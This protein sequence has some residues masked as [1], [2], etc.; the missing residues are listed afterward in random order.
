MKRQYRAV[1]FDLDTKA[2]LE[3]LGSRTKG[4]ALI[5]KSMKEF[6]FVHRQ[7]SGYRSI[8]PLN[9][10]EIVAFV[11]KIG[12]SNP[13]L[14]DCVKAFDVT[15]SGRTDFDFTE[16]L[17]QSAR[18]VKENVED[19]ELEQNQEVN[20]TT[21]NSH[22]MTKEEFLAYEPKVT[23]VSRSDLKNRISLS[24]AEEENVND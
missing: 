13:W 23:S 6:G 5:K 11:K 10:D 22:V 19:V 9:R 3:V 1:N 2:M 15:D 24:L 16:A 12:I 21:S 8:R 17:K 20:Q 7:G 18:S 4:Y 14:A